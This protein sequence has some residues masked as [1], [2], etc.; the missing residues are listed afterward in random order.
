MPHRT[1]NI[2]KLGLFSPRRAPHN[3]TY[4][5]QGEFHRHRSPLRSWHLMQLLKELKAE[6][7]VLSCTQQP[8]RAKACLGKDVLCGV[9]WGW[10]QS[11][12]A[13]V[14]T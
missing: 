14:L 9:A 2:Q 3:V 6:N 10:G 5:P 7:Q 4:K 12:D 11:L 1:A 8:F 13:P